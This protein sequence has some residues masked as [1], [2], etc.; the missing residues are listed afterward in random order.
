MNNSIS[1]L[2]GN[3][4]GTF[5]QYI[6]YTVLLETQFIQCIKAGD[7]NEDSKPDLVLS[8]GSILFNSCP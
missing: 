5:Q 1:V 4:D 3:A 6:D 7:F 8:S 2:V